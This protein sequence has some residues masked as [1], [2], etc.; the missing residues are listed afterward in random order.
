MGSHGGKVPPYSVLSIAI[1]QRGKMGTGSA[2]LRWQ[3]SADR[4]RRLIPWGPRASGLLVL[5][6]GGGERWI[7][8]LVVSREIYK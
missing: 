5:R 8:G 6:V 1:A 7:G 2:L 3:R 4:L